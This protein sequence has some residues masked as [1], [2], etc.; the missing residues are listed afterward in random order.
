MLAAPMSASWA[1]GLGSLALGGTAA[2]VLWPRAR[3]DR[4][5]I[6]VAAAMIYLTYA[7]TYSCRVSLL[8]E[9]Y[10]TE[11][12][13]LYFYA[14]RYHV[15]PLL[16]AAATLAAVAASI[17]LV[18]RCDCYRG[19]PAALG[20][21]C[22]LVLMFA[23]E[24]EATRWDWMLEQPDQQATMEALHRLGEVARD[25][26]I[27]REQLLRVVAPIWR[28]WNGSVFHCRPNAS[29]LAILCIQ[30][31]EGARP[32]MSDQAAFEV[33]RARLT[34]PER[35]AIGAGACVFGQGSRPGPG[36][37][38]LAVARKARTERAQETLP[39]R[40]HMDDAGAFVEYE[41]DSVAGARY[42]V[43]PGLRSD[44]DLMVYWCAASAVWYPGWNVHWFANP[45]PDA[46]AV[47]DIDR[48]IQWTGKPISRIRIVS[49][50]PGN[51]CLD[52]PPR[53]SR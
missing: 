35:M 21:T 31:P 7:L 1:W 23:Q 10:W 6:L 27:T 26:G 51:L 9:G 3:W 25:E 44:Q 14:G 2:L 18:R 37:A 49:A 5:L 16:G 11:P 48:L 28:P 45:R 34:R 22:G 43:L 36:V 19:V 8:K 38:T 50:G 41:I 53:L 30:A 12:Q 15:L 24:G 33:I 40:Y 39:G 47:I 29:H 42:L 17:P 32:I 52:A 46:M 20:L 13:L 4:R